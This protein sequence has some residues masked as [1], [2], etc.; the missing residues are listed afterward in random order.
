MPTIQ[1]IEGEK[2]RETLLE[3]ARYIA[4]PVIS[5]LG[6]SG[7]TVVI[8]QS[9]FTPH[10]TKDGATVA[11]HILP[12]D[13]KL[14]AGAVQISKAAIETANVAGDGPQP[15]YS[16]VLTPTG[17]KTMGELRVGD[18]V[19]GTDGTIQ[20]VLGVFPKGEKE[21]VE[22]TF[23]D[24]RLVQ[25]CEDHLW[26][27]KTS[28]GRD[29]T[30]TTKE[31]ISQGV[32]KKNPDGTNSHR[33]YTPITTVDFIENRDK[34][35]IDP[36]LLGLLIGDGSLSGTGS[37]ELSIGLNKQ[38]I[39]E[40]I[41]LPEGITFNAKVT[42]KGNS[43]RVKFIGTDQNGKYLKDLLSQIGLLGVKSATKFIPKEYLYSSIESRKQLLQGLLDTDGHINE[44]GLFDYSTISES[45]FKDFKD[46]C[47]GL[48]LEV[49]GYKHA[50]KANSSYSGTPI[51]RSTQRRGYKYGSKILDI[52]RTGKFTQMQCIK[53]SNPDNLYIT[54]GY[55]VT[56]NTT[57][58]MALAL[59]LVEGGMKLVAQGENP[60]SI[61]A[62]MQKACDKVCEYLKSIAIPVTGDMLLHVATISSNGDEAMG[63][64]V[65]EAYKA[66]KKG[67]AVTIMKSQTGSTRIETV[68]GMQIDGGTIQ[69][70]IN[71]NK[72]RRCVLVNPLVVLTTEN[73]N[74]YKPLIEVCKYAREQGR[75]LLIIADEISGEALQ[76]LIANMHDRQGPNGIEK[77]LQS[78]VVG[79][80]QL[81]RTN[82]DAIK[83][84]SIVTGAQVLTKVSPISKVTKERFKSVLGSVERAEAYL[85]R[86]SIIGGEGTK[87]AIEQRIEY[88]KSQIAES[89]NDQATVDVLEARLAG[90]D[91]GI[92]IIHVGGENET[93]TKELLDRY[94][95][96]VRAVRGAMKSGVLP[97]GGSALAL[98]QR[99]FV[100]NKKFENESLGERLLYAS[101][102]EPLEKICE[103]SV[104][105]TDESDTLCYAI[106]EK[107]YDENIGYNFKTKEYGD[108]IQMGVIDPAIVPIT[109]LQKA[110]AVAGNM[111]TTEHI[112]VNL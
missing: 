5:T 77:G 65:D 97:G 61:K 34:M 28:W 9:G 33:F 22:L 59:A 103:N 64:L 17:W 105:S 50:R 87:D 68:L 26:K 6:P 52:K 76:F 3:G 54:D 70:F 13:K 31:M 67:G 56:H 48:G 19:C 2:C 23:S 109:A 7:K 101:L 21:I 85:D 112:I 69:Q 81:T 25:C 30:L 73:I 44:R 98:T 32:F 37:I 4:N 96:A 99:A 53:V 78:C 107:L 42:P 90:I 111:I 12:E 43:L 51:F 39:L 89:G 72:N 40:K 55:S 20:E 93:H 38:H 27:I 92:S 80:S 82:E 15:L 46:L 83:D 106:L 11:K 24:G 100:N 88:I 58:S 74:T 1:V 47:R 86:T 41:I 91:G 102:T 62:G 104:R 94:D 57:T 10:V 49:G 60:H 108:M 84:I 36:Y 14:A 110:V 18:Y 75:P 45:L 8:Y 71:D 63:R 16:N 95:D 35:P 29:F 79:L 66:V